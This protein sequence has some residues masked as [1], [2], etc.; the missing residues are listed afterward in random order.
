MDTTLFKGEELLTLTGGSST[1]VNV[2]DHWLRLLLQRLLLARVDNSRDRSRRRHRKRLRIVC[3]SI[4]SN[5]SRGD[6]GR[7]WLWRYIIVPV[8]WRGQ[9]QLS[10]NHASI[11]CCLKSSLLLKIITSSNLFI[12][13][14]GI[15]ICVTI[16]VSS[17]AFVQPLF[18]AA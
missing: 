9:F 2:D 18:L 16:G 7:Q 1:V 13:H 14:C 12:I 17:T 6:E 11:S 4:R 3:R 15:I 8:G 5:R 10:I